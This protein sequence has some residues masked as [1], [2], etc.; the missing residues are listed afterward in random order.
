MRNMIP[1]KKYLCNY[2]V[3]SSLVFIPLFIAMLAMAP[4]WLFCLLLMG[5]LGLALNE[6]WLMICPAES[7]Y[8]KWFAFALSFGLAAAAYEGGITIFAGFFVLIT[9]VLVLVILPLDLDEK[10]LHVLGRLLIIIIYLPFLLSHLLLLWDLPDGRSLVAMVFLV[11]WGG[12]AFSYYSGTAW[13]R[14][15]L[16]ANISPNKTIEGSVGGVLGAGLFSLLLA[17]IGLVSSPWFFILI[18]G[19]IANVVGQLGDLFESYLKRFA[20]LKDSGVIVPGHGGVLDRID[21]VLFAV[22]V[23]YYGMLVLG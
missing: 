12:D 9:I 1:W 7:K 13:G 10:G 8:L 19:M 3:Y 23:I 5:A 15:K 6:L 2:R 22:P 21:S 16:A 17:G 4:K 18:L 20:G 11:T 14:H